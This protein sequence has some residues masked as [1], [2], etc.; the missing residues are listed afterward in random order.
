MT[1]IVGCTSSQTITDSASFVAAISLDVG[2]S[3]TSVY[4]FYEP[5]VDGVRVGYCATTGHVIDTI[6]IDVGVGALAVGSGDVASA[7]GASFTSTC[8]PTLASPSCSN[9][10]VTSTSYIHTLKFY[11][12]TSVYAVSADLSHTSPQVTVTITCA[13]TSTTISTSIITSYT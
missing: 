5:S 6:T 10:D 13:A 12:I 4:T 1:L 3:P 8:S 2:D 7:T 9:I 11:I